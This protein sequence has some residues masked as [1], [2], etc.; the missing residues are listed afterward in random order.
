MRL[1]RTEIVERLEMFFLDHQ[2]F[3]VL[4]Q[5]EPDFSDR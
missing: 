4:F 1:P 3:T 2:R 5:E